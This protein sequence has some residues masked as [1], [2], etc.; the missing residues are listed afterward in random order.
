MLR[1]LKIF[2]FSGTGNAKNVASWFRE[3]AEEKEFIIEINDLSKI[4]RKNISQPNPNTL[5][6]IISPTHGFNFP[7]VTMY[8][9]FRFPKAGINNKVF[10]INTRAGMKLGKIYFP[11]LSG[12]TL[13]LASIVLL[14]KGYKI[15]GLRSIDLPSN[16]ISLH[17]SL[18]GNAVVLIHER[19][20]KITNKFAEDILSGRK[21][22]RAVYDIIQ[23]VLI[24]PISIGYFLAGRFMFAKSFYANSFCDK[25]YTCINNCPVG[26]I[27]KVNDQPYWTYHCES[28][29]KCMNECPKRAVET[30][31]GY[32][33]GLLI[34]TNSFILFHFWN[35]I[36]NFIKINE[37]DTLFRTARSVIDTIVYFILLFISYRVIHSIKR[38]PVF[39]QVIEY[40]SL[41]KYNFWGRYN[42]K[43][44]FASRKRN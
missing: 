11:G 6:G 33:I 37:Y 13:W 22:F 23:D 18:R 14:L 41:T 35:Y 12:I 29:M 34:F 7:P 28:C 10:I 44:I 36:F 8:F 3:K 20:K 38:M 5:I 19:C 4:N 16:W 15:I 26:A 40:T 2:F 21:N 27:K 32:I 30:G 43:K 31:H 42:A 24:S 17:P 1:Q 25:C 39:K 9:I